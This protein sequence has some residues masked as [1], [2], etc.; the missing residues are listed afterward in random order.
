MKQPQGIPCGFS[1]KKEKIPLKKK[2]TQVLTNPFPYSDSN[3]RYYTY[4]YYLKQRYGGKCAKI[5]LDAGFTCP[6]IDGRCG[7][8]G[9]IYCSSRG[10]G[11]FTAGAH[12][13]IKEQFEVQKEKILKKWPGAKLIPYLQAHTNTYAALDE[14]Q[15]VYEEVL[16]LPDTVAFH[17]A[18]RADCL[19]DETVSYLAKIAKRTDLT[20]EL[21]LQSVKDE[22]AALINRG[23]T[24]ADFLDGYN[25]LRAASDKIRIAVH[26]IDGLP[27]ETKEDML[28][29][30]R[31]VGRL[32]PDEI[33]I[34]LLHVLKGTALARL[35]EREEYLPMNENEY[36]EVVVEQLS[37]LPSDIVIG[38]LT[39]DGP[40]DILLAPLWSK[41]KTVILN[42][43]DKMLFCHNLWQGKCAK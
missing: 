36:V 24:Y 41:R 34:H 11:D 18:T 17:I 43:I 3:K 21:G 12:L 30:A 15:R 32:H 35:Y 33:K 9:C 8:G 42:E 5:T 19:P 2:E 29:S 4:D 38:R 20:V 6:N 22:T 23:H 28:A 14:L 10:S 27:G 39:G 37:L 13:S 40:A 31:E 16:A 7:V 26:L 1:L 25:R